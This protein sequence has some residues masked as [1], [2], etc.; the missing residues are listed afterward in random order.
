MAR[1]YSYKTS[2]TAGEVSTELAGRGDLTAYDN[3]AGKLS[4]IFVMPT[5]GVTR[6][7]GLR[8]VDTAP[9]EGR[10]VAFE[11]NTEQVY[12]LLF[13]EG[14]VDVYENGVKIATLAGTPWTLA[15]VKSINWVQSA[16]TLLVVHPDVAPKKITRDKAGIWS[17][18]DWV[19]FEK[20]G[21]IE[22]PHHKFAAEAVTL[23]PSATTGTITLNA[24]ADVFDPAMHVGTRFRLQNKEVEITAVAS[25]TSATALVKETLLATSATKEWEE[26]AFS[27][28]RGWPVSACFHQDRLVIGG[29][30]DLPN[31]LWMSKSSDLFNFDL[32]T[33]LDDEAIE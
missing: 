12:L 22:Q 29:S 33:G 15:Q 6:R 30:R 4:N 18:A 3:G 20:D 24:S 25:A 32:A 27:I 11:F 5:G 19:Y 17:I 28:A 10:L 7:A 1:I 26:Q 21:V 8:Y 31:R 23:S 13:Y 16:D 14:N 2:F 9:S